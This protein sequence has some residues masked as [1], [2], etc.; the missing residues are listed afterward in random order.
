MASTEN[1]NNNNTATATATETT[2]NN[3]EYGVLFITGEEVSFPVEGDY[4]YDYKDRI[5]RDEFNDQVW[6][7]EWKG[8]RRHRNDYIALDPNRELHVCAREK[9]NQHYTYYGKIRN[10]T[11]RQIHEGN[12]AEGDPSAY[13]FRLDIN[14]ETRFK[15]VLSGDLPPQAQAVRS[16]GFNYNGGCSG[17][18]KMWK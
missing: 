5:Y 10:D 14:T 16:L 18:Y 13:F 4:D 3:Q 6:A 15:T 11:V 1:N 7:L 12:P 9:K 2:D 17:I 8:Q